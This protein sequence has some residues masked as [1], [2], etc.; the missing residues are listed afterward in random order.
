MGRP[1]AVTIVRLYVNPSDKTQNGTSTPLV[2]AF[3]DAFPL[4]VD[5]LASAVYKLYTRSYSNGY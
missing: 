5:L 3:D 1:M 4:P 2:S